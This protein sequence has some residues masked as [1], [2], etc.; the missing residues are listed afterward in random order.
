MWESGNINTPSSKTAEDNKRDHKVEETQKVSKEPVSCNNADKEG[1]TSNDCGDK[2]PEWYE[3]LK[4]HFLKWKQENPDK[5]W[6]LDTVLYED[7]DIETLRSGDVN[8]E[9]RKDEDVKDT[10]ENNDEETRK[11][12]H[13]QEVFLD[14]TQESEEDMYAPFGG[15]WKY[16]KRYFSTKVHNS[17]IESN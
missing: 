16:R 4:E 5:C 12:Y 7:E 13:R 8:Q 9:E 6:K 15:W 17:K 2:E 3:N 11:Y 14:M 1:Q 10:S